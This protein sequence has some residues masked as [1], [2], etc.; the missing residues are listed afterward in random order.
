[1]PA[2]SKTDLAWF[3]QDK[4]RG[5]GKK[6]QKRPT[7]KTFEF[8]VGFA[9]SFFIWIAHKNSSLECFNRFV[10]GLFIPKIYEVQ[11]WPVARFLNLYIKSDFNGVFST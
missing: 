9:C 8:K 7:P 10:V 6:S 3:F 5:G 2:F 11:K 4:E 1:M